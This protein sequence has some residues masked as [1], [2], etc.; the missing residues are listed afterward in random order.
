ML[1]MYKSILGADRLGVATNTP[2]VYLNAAYRSSNDTVTVMILDKTGDAKEVSVDLHGFIE[3]NSHYSVETRRFQAV[4]GDEK[5]DSAER[6]DNTPF[7]LKNKRG[8]IRVSLEP[9]TLTRVVIHRSATPFPVSTE[10]K[11]KE[12]RVFVVA[13]QSN[14]IGPPDE[15]KFVP[16]A[17]D[18]RIM[19]SYPKI[20]YEFHDLEL[21]SGRAGVEVEI[22]RSALDG[23]T[24]DGRVAIIKF[25]KG[26]SSLADDWYAGD[27][28][29]KVFL[30]G[31]KAKVALLDAYAKKNDLK[32]RFSGFYWAQGENDAADNAH[33]D[34]YGKLL[35][36]LMHEVR[37]VIGPDPKIVIAELN[38]SH[39]G[40]ARDRI[41]A[42]EENIGDEVG[43]ALI[44][45]DDLTL[46]PGNLHY[47][48]DSMREMGRRA[49][50]ALSS[51]Q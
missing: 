29:A 48:W 10:A 47:N 16:L 27:G 20:G 6:I 2:G 7:T 40:A 35:R 14:A 44:R 17:R 37:D 18:K 5:A 8:R 33:A 25:A 34:K 39:G 31:L 24:S 15:G 3:D 23:L 50:K 38:K 1:S 43:Y 21:Q 49:Y 36:R 51:G 26:N 22:G 42:I 9:F 19:L 12:L 28:E 41:R 45:G 32:L 11:A 4:K 30:D 46:L 13:G